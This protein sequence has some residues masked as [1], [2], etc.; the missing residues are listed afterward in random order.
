MKDRWKAAALLAV[1]GALVFCLCA[2]APAQSI[3]Q[4]T[5]S[6]AGTP[7]PTPQPTP[8]PPAEPVAFEVQGGEGLPLANLTDESTATKIQFAQQQ[9]LTVQAQQPIGGL[10][11]IFD[12]P[13]EW[14]LQ[15]GEG[16]AVPQGQQGFLHQYVPLEAPAQSLRL[17]L[18]QGAVL[19]QVNAFTQ[20]CPPD[21]VQQW[22][23]PCEKADLLV[24][25]THADDEHL[26]FGGALPY[27][28]GEKGYAVQVAYM[29]NHW[30]E[31]YRPHELLNGLWAVGVRNYPVISDFAD[32]YAS[33]ES[34][35]S[36]RAVYDEQAVTAFQVE[37]LRRFKP[38][39]VLGHDIDGEYGHGAHMLNA[40]T[41]LAALQSSA[42]PDAFPQS[43]R[44]Y[45]TW[46]V[47]KCYLHLWPENT[48][49]MQWSQMP[50]QAF[51]GRT[52]LEMAAQGFACHASQTQWFQVQEGGS[53]DCRKFGLAYT[54]VGLDEQKNDFFEHI[55]PL[56]ETQAGA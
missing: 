16:E 12:R 44:Q 22:Q 31:P 19:C 54:N 5:A 20:G 32:L 6:P 26:W 43:A 52:A 47:P 38:S 21:W 37:L 46:Q 40:V 41:L 51:G 36:A 18:P 53:N 2:C 10:Y 39:V 35:E 11:L 30:A 9:T 25:P 28:A 50:L 15:A 56:P 14:Q 29:T 8:Q 7:S 55:S 4:P 49:E 45:G 42:D 34:L 17:T 33:K 24:L 48:L 23:P 3:P 13:V 1:G 27:Y